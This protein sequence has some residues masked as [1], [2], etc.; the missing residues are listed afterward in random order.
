M[1]MGHCVIGLTV[2]GRRLGRKG[3]QAPQ[4]LNMFRWSWELSHRHRAYQR[5]CVPGLHVMNVSPM[6]R[7][8][9]ALQQ[10]QGPELVWRE[11]AAGAASTWVALVEC[12]VTNPGTPH[13]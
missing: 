6:Y 11:A 13:N 7:P 2:I 4:M 3:G 10:G 1:F 9:S 5:H 8:T 12:G